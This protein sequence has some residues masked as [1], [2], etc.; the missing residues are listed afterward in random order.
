MPEGQQP[1]EFEVIQRLARIETRQEDMVRRLD[2][3][4]KPSKLNGGNGIGIAQQANMLRPAG[5]ANGFGMGL[6][7]S[8]ASLSALAAVGKAFG[9]W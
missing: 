5:F 4:E 7:L 2:N 1:F 6:G 3:L 8:I 9:W